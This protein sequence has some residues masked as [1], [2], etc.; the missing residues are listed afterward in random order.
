MFVIERKEEGEGEGE[1]RK[2]KK[3]EAVAGFKSHELTQVGSG[4]LGQDCHRL[5]LYLMFP[6]N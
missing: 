5:R 4:S 6:F 3:M 1:K 2:K